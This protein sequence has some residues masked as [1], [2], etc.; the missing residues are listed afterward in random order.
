[1][2]QA[3]DLLLDA[4]GLSRRAERVLR[5]P[6]AALVLLDAIR[7]AI[8]MERLPGMEPRAAYVG[9]G[10][11]AW[12]SGVTGAVYLLDSSITL[13]TLTE[14]RWLH[15]DVFSCAPFDGGD[16]VALVRRSC[17]GHGRVMM[18]NRCAGVVVWRNEW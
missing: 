2:H 11:K 6:R 15:L 14:G 3:Y 1:M 4:W 10:D 12:G 13:H 16:V 7:V 18:V 17:G 9:G 8:G 5:E